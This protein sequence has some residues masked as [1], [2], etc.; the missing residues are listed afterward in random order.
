MR[1]NVV[2]NSPRLLELKRKKHK[3]ARRKAIILLVIILILILGL[4]LASRISA[5]KINSVLVSGNKIIETKMIEE[6][7]NKEL[8]GNYLWIFPKTNFLIYPKHKILSQLNNKFK[9]LKK[10]S[11]NVNNFKSLDILVSEHE[12]KYLWCGALIPVL[13]N[14][15]DNKCYFLDS[16]GYIFDE[17]PY[18]S[19]E[20][21]FKFYGDV[22][23]DDKN[24]SGSYFM[25]D[26]FIKIIEFKNMIEKMNLKP[27]A[28][29]IDGNRE[30]GNFSL[31]GEPGTSP[32]IIFKIDSDY[33]KLAENLQAA[34]STEP[35]RTDLKTKLSS[36]LYL[37]LR[38][39][40]KVYYKFQ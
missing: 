5:F 28:F 24:P 19:G 26:K 9:R 18:F 20:V 29:W 16:D 1:K 15:G 6:I 14:T 38:F 2:L 35:L 12:G 4:S 30:E 22:G 34:I 21:Y 25:K 7:I 32:H 36:L 31:S 23:S 11:I 10:I 13:M 39:G 8:A 17:A 33:E 40:N 27:T 37:D 3:F